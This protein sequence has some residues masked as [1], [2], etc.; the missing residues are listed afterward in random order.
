MRQLVE[1]DKLRVAVDEIH[2][3]AGDSAKSRRDQARDRRKRKDGVQIANLDVGD[4]V[5]IAKREFLKGEKLTLRW[6]GPR[7]V[8]RVLSEFLFEVEDIRDGTI[9][10]VHSSRIRLYQDSKLNKTD[11]LVEHVAH[12]EEGFV[13]DKLQDLRYVEEEKR[14]DVNVVWKGFEMEDSTWEPL[15]NLIE[16]VPVL[17][18]K[19]LSKRKDKLACDAMN[20]FRSFIDRQKA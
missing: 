6:R 12:T 9:T 16:D 14:Y 18:E 17:L 15:N 8:V 2:K 20:V 7:R 19:F 10:T 3:H 13:V 1:I 5:L 11:D 4:F